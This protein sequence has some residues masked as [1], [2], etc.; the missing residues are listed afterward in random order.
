MQLLSA[1]FV[2][3]AAQGAVVNAAAIT[4]TDTPSRG[5]ATHWCNHGTG[6]NGGC[7]ANGLHTYCC[8][9]RKTNFFEVPRQVTVVSQNGEGSSNC[10]NGGTIYCS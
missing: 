2:A 5:V 9:L 1:I 8:A 7:E 4:S 6:G 3:I 10:A